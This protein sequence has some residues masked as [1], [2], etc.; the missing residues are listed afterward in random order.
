V[1]AKD[2]RTNDSALIQQRVLGQSSRD[3]MI[4]LHD[5]YDGTSRPS[6]NAA[7]SS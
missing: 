7:T 1:T 3:G 2:H 4:L 6:R 5:L